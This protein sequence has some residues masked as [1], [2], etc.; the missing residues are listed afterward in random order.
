MAAFGWNILGEE[1]PGAALSSEDDSLLLQEVS[2]WEQHSLDVA[3]KLCWT[4]ERNFINRKEAFIQKWQQQARPALRML[5]VQ[6]CEVDVRDGSANA[7]DGL[8]V[9]IVD[10]VANGVGGIVANSGGGFHDIAD[11]TTDLDIDLFDCNVSVVC[12]DFK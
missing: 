2:H 9:D 7:L 4:N 1:A 10:D 12:C 6:S 5:T 11:Q 3:S 8:Q